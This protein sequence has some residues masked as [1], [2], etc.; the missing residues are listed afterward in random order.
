[1]GRRP[2]AHYYG[3]LV[4]T[5]LLEARPAGLST[6]QLVAATGQSPARVRRGIGHLRDVAAAEH[7]TPIVW[8]RRE[9]YLFSHDPADWIAY[10]KAQ[11]RTILN[12]LTRLLTGTLDPHAARHP[13]D[14]WAQVAIAQLT[15]IRATLAQLAK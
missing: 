10:E 3:D 8:T 1:M 13:E 6:R 2:V 14:E 11:F 15:G 12:R 5:A 9:G 4:R 7:L